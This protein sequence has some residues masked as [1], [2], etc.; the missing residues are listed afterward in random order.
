MLLKYG[1]L[2]LPAGNI[3]DLYCVRLSN[4]APFCENH[5]KLYFDANHLKK[6]LNRCAGKGAGVEFLVPFFQ[7]KSPFWPISNGALTF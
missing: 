2:M 7:K 4:A 6:E 1:N 5:I 3:L